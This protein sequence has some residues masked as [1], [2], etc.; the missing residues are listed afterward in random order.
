MKMEIKTSVLIKDTT[1]EQ[2]KKI[3]ED[4]LALTTLDAPRPS[5]DVLKLYDEYIEGRIELAEVEKNVLERYK[6][7]YHA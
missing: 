4:G 6:R 2:R 3:V 5:D 7:I 1:K